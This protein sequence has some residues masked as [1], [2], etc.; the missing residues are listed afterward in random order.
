MVMGHLVEMRDKIRSLGHKPLFMYGTLL[1]AIREKDFIPHDDD[2][3]LAVIMDGVGPEQIS[4]ECDK[5][6]ELLNE[7]GVKSNR[8]VAHAPLIHCHRGPITYDI[9]LF[10]HQDGTV[11]WQHTALKTVSERADIFLPTGTIEFKGEIFDAPNNPEAVCE[12]RY[13]ADWRVPN[14]AFEW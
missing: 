13:G 14:A 3:D 2:L 4:A 11:Y 8:G 9:F 1:G 6:I 7:N 10:A 12:A 5:F